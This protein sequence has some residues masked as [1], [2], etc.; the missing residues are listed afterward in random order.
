MKVSK[1]SNSGCPDAL[2]RGR[3]K[4]DGGRTQIKTVHGKACLQATPTRPPRC[5]PEDFDGIVVPRLGARQAAPL[6]GS[7]IS[8]GRN[9]PQGKIVAAICHAGLVL[10]SAGIVRGHKATGSEGSRT[11]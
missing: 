8:G 10:I 7:I 2:A 5:P 4:R 1:I 6:S 9:L 3:G 11:T